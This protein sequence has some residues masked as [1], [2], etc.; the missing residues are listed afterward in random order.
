MATRNC[1]SVRMPVM[2]NSVGTLPLRKPEV[3]C[4]SVV[5]GAIVVGVAAKG[6]PGKVPIGLA[7]VATP[8][9]DGA[10]PACPPIAPLAISVLPKNQSK[11]RALVSFWEISTNLALMLTWGGTMLR[12]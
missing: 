3:N 10:V 9:K 11:P 2:V 6:L 1:G 8:L 12:T 7:G 4:W 5:L